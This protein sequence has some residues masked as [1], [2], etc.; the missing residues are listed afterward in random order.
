MNSIYKIVFNK[1]TGTY[2]AVA[3]FA[4]SHTRVGGSSVSGDLS[5]SQNHGKVFTFSTI[6]IAIALSNISY[7]QAQE[8]ALSADAPPNISIGRTLSR[9][10]DV[11]ASEVIVFPGPG[12]IATS[13]P[14]GPGKPIFHSPYSYY[15]PDNK[16]DLGGI[17]YHEKAAGAIAIGSHVDTRSV[18]DGIASGIGLGSYI[19]AKGALSL[20]L[21]SYSSALG[22]S[23]VSL[24]TAAQ[25]KGFNSLAVSRQASAAQDFSMAIGTASHAGARYATAIGQSAQATG[26]GAVALGSAEMEEVLTDDEG[27]YKVTRFN[28]KTNTQAKGKNSVA[29]GRSAQATE[30]NAI[31]QGTRSRAT[32]VNTIAQGTDAK[33]NKI[34]AQAFG[35]RAQASGVNAIAQGASAKAEGVNSIAKG[36]G[37]NATGAGAIAV[38]FVANAK[39]ENAQ[40]FGRGAFADGKNT[41]ALGNSAAALGDDSQAMGV[42]AKS[43]GGRSLALGF[44]AQTDE[45]ANGGLALGNKASVTVADGVALGAHSLGDRKHLESRMV[46]VTAENA[47]AAENKVYSPL[48]QTAI[49]NTKLPG[50]NIEG[51]TQNELELFNE[52]IKNTVKGEYG[53][54]SVGTSTGTRQIINVAAGSEDSDAVNVAQLKALA[55]LPMIF[56]ADD[57]RQ[58]ERK[59]G[60]RLPIKGGFTGEE[61]KA[62]A[63]NIITKIDTDNNTIEVA[64]KPD[65][66]G[67]HSLQF[68]DG[69]GIKIGDA[70]TKAQY[71]ESLA[72]G[73]GAKAEYNLGAIAIGTNAATSYSSQ[74]NVFHANYNNPYS[75]FNLGKDPKSL[76]NRVTDE[77]KRTPTGVNYKN[78]VGSAAIAI[79]RNSE[80][81]HGGVAL[82]DGAQALVA[83]QRGF[84]VAIGA[85]ALSRGGGV[86][87]GS[88]AEAVGINSVAFGRQAVAKGGSAQAYGAASSAVGEKSLALGHS[89]QSIGRR[90]IAIGGSSGN[91][92]EKY[93]DKTNTKAVADDSI[94]IGARTRTG[95]RAYQAIAIG[96]SA[97]ASGVSATAIGTDS[98]ASDH[99]SQALGATA[100]ATKFG[101]QAFGLLASAKERN[102]IA[103]GTGTKALGKNSQ[104]LGTKAE[105]RGERSLAAGFE[106][107]TAKDAANALALGSKANASVA[108]GVALGSESVADRD[109][110]TQPAV[111]THTATFAGGQ[112]YTPISDAVVGD[113]TGST[114]ALTKHR[115][116]VAATT[117][118]TKAAVS[119]GGNGTTRQITNLAAGS[120]DTDAVN[121]A[122]LKSLAAMP[123]IFQADQL[124]QV[125][126]KL[127]ESLPIKG[128]T[129]GGIITKADLATNGLTIEVKPNMAKGIK[130]DENG[131]GVNVNQQGPLTVDDQGLSLT[132]DGEILEITGVEGNKKLSAKA[133]KF[134]ADTG[135]AT[136]KDNAV[137]FDGEKNKLGV[138]GGQTIVG[139]QQVQN[140][141]NIETK[142]DKA[143]NKIEVALK[144]D[145]TNLTSLQFADGKGIKI[146]DGETKATHNDMIAIGKGATVTEG[147][148]GDIGLGLRKAL[149]FNE[150]LSGM[151]TGNHDKYGAYYLTSQGLAVGNQAHSG[152]FATSLGGRAKAAGM[153]A[154]A[155]GTNAY[156]GKEGTVALGAGSFAA[157]ASG[158][159][160]GRE[161]VSTGK[162]AQ[163]LGSVSSATGDK[164]FA[165]GHSATASGKRGIAIGASSNENGTLYQQYDKNGRATTYGAQALG[166]DSI[167]LGSGSVAEQTN[168]LAIGRGAQATVADGVALGSGSKADRGAIQGVST[169]Q[170]ANT[171]N[172][173]YSPTQNEELSTAI[174]DTVKG[175]LGAVSVGDQD[176]TRQITNVAAGSSDTDA[177]NIAQLRALANLPMTFEA[178]EGGQVER[179]LG[180]RLPVKGKENGGITT[181]TNLQTNGIDIA[182]KADDKKGVEVGV[183]GVAV[184]LNTDK[185]VKFGTDG[186]VEVNLAN[187]KGLE[188]DGASD[189]GIAVKAGNGI[190]VNATGVNV[191]PKDQGALTVNADGVAVNVN[192]QKGIEIGTDNKLA[193]KAN[194]TKGIKVDGD[195]IGINLKAGDNPLHFDDQGAL[196][197]NA[198]NVV[199]QAQLPVVYTDKAGNKLTKVGDKFYQVNPLNGNPTRQE[200][201]PNEVIASMNNG[202]NQT[203]NAPMTLANVAHNITPNKDLG[204]EVISYANKPTRLQ[205]N[206]AATVGDVLN[207]GFNLKQRG[208]N[209]D[210]VQAFDT[211]DIIDGAGTTAQ[212]T[213][214]DK[215]QVNQIT[216]NVKADHQTGIKVTD[217]GV[218][219]NIDDNAGLEFKPMTDKSASKL[220]VKADDTTIKV[221]NNTVK[222]KTTTLTPNENGKINTPADGEGDALVTAQ[223]VADAINNSGFTLQANGQDGKL[224]KAGDT[225]SINQ[226]DNINVTQDENGNLTVATKQDVAFETVKVGDT[227]QVDN[228]LKVGDINI[229]PE[230]ITVGNTTDGRQVIRVTSE[231]NAGNEKN[232]ITGLSDTLPRQGDAATQQAISADLDI[233]SDQ[234]DNAKLSR[235]ATVADALSTGFNLQENGNS[236]DFVRAYDTVNF[237]DSD[238]VQTKVA[239]DKDGKISR[240]SNE[241]KVNPNQGLERTQA[242]VGIKLKPSAGNPL[243]VNEYGL[244]LDYDVDKLAVKDQILTVNTTDLFV[245]DDPDNE[246]GNTGRV[247]LD[248]P[249]KAKA[250]VTAQGVADAIN[251]SGFLL[252]AE[253]ETVKLVSPGDSVNI[254]A[255]KTDQGNGNIRVFEDNG[256]IVIGTA[257]DVN[258]NTVKVEEELKVGDVKIDQDGINA[259]N[260]QITNVKEGEKDTDA[261]NVKQLKDSATKYFADTDF[262]ESQTAATSKDKAKAAKDNVIG[263]KGGVTGDEKQDGAS[264]ITTKLISDKNTLEVTLNPV[265]KGLKSI[266][267]AKDQ[268]VTMGDTRTLASNP[269]ATAIG[270]GANATAFGSHAFG[271]DAMANADYA[272]ALGNRAIATAQGAQAMGAFSSADADFAQALGMAAIANKEGALALGAAAEAKTTGG[273]ALGA[274]SV[275]DREAIVG[276]TTSQTAN[277]TNQVYSPTQNEE[278]STAITATVKGNLGAVSV[279]DKNNTRQITN[280]AAGSSDTD[281]AN[282]AQLKAVAE[283][284]FTVED[285][286]GGKAAVKLG[287]NL[288]VKGKANSGITTSVNADKDGIDI[289]VK[290]GNGIEVNATGVN[291][292]PK[293]Q[294]ALTVNAD[295]VAVNVNNQKGIEIGTDN[296]LAVKANTTK[297][298]KVD[299]DGIG[300]NLKAGDNPLHFDDQGALTF[301]AQ[302]VVEQAQLPVVYTD[303]AGNKLTKV[304]DKFYQVNPLNGNPTRQEVAPNE[305][306]ASMNNGL[307]QTQNAPMTLANVA[308]NIT[309][310]KDLG[311][312]VISYANKPTRLQENNAATVG[313]VL[314]AGFNLKQR[315]NNKDFVQA[316]DTLDIIDG[317]GTTAQVTTDDKHQVNQIT[318]NVKAD[319]QT[320]I[321]VTDEGVGINIDDNAGL[322]FKPMTDKSASKLAVKADD[323]TIKVENNTVKAKTTTLTPNE[324]GKINTPAD[325]E[326]D[327]LVTAQTVADA[328]NNSG[329]TLQAN[330]QDGKLVK[331]GDTISIN[332]GDNINVTQDE[333]GNLTVATKQDVA[334]ETVKVGD[335]LQVDNLLKVGDINITPEGITVGNTTDGRQVIRVTSEGNAGNEKNIITGLS[336]TLPRQGDAA[337]QQAISADLD[338]SSDQ[339]D[340]AKLSR[341]ATVADALSTGFNLQENGAAKDFVKAYDTIDFVDGQGTRVMVDSP[342]GD[343]KNTIR[344]DLNLDPAKGLEINQEK[345]GLL[346]IKLR[347]EDSNPL[348]VDENGLTVLTTNLATTADGKL[349]EPD[350]ADENSLVNAKSIVDAINHSGFVAKANGDAGEVIHPGDVLELTNGRN[351][352][353]SRDGGKFT[354]NTA[355]DAIFNSLSV[356]GEYGN[357]MIDEHGMRMGDVHIGPTGIN[358]GDTRITNVADGVDPS[359]AVNVSQLLNGMAQSAEYVTSEDGSIFVQQSVNPSTKATTFDLS[360]NTDDVTITKGDEGKIKAKTTTLTPNEQTGKINT[361]AD[362]E[363]DA[364]VTANTVADAINNSGFTVQAN[365]KDGKLVKAGD[366][367]NFVNG[368]LTTV[369]L[370]PGEN[371]QANTIKVDV[372]AQ[373]LV[374]NAQLPVVYTDKKGNK[375]AKTADGKFVRVNPLTGKPLTNGNNEIDPNEA[376][377]SLNNG[378]NSVQEPMTLN[379]LKHNIQPQPVLDNK[380]TH[381]NK[382]VFDERSLTNAATVG[383]VLNAGFN[384]RQDGTVKDFVQAFDAIDFVKGNATSVEIETNDD[385]TQSKV[386]I[387]I[388]ADNKTIEVKDSQ[389]SAK[390]TTLTPNENGKINTPADGEGDALVTAQTV[391]DAINN[392]GF[393]LQANGQDGKLIKAGDTIS[394]NQGDNIN[395]TQDEN[396]NL[397]VA[398]K[399]DVAFETVK[400]GDTLQV[401]NLLKVGDINITPEGINAGGKKVTNVADGTDDTD[402]VNVK[403]LKDART[404]VTSSDNS[405]SVVDTN[406]GQDGKNLA[407]DI[408]VDSQALVESAQLPVVYTDVYGNRLYKQ[409]DG[410]FAT[411]DGKKVDPADVIASINNGKGSTTQPTNL[412]NVAGNLTPT[413]NAGDMIVGPDGKLIN[414]PVT[415]ATRVQEAPQGQD[416]ANMYNNAATVGDVLNAGFNLQENGWSRDFVKAYDMVNF[417]DGEGT[418]A[419][420]IT[421]QNGKESMIK[422]DINVDDTKGLTIAPNTGKLGI[423][424]N[425]DGPLITD[426]DGLN[427]QTDGSTIKVE[428]NQLIANTATLDDANKD[429]KIEIGHDGDQNALIT[430]G[431]VANAINNSGW[432]VTSGATGTGEVDG[433]TTELINPSETVTFQAGDNLVLNQA[434]NVFTYSLNNDIN[435]SSVQFNDGPKITS[436]GDNIRVESPTGEP[437]K[438]TN[439]QAGTDN[440]DAVNVSQLKDAQAA[441]TTKVEEADGINVEAT[442][443]KDGSTTYTV[444]AKTDGVTTYV[445]NNGNIAA[446]TGDLNTSTDGSVSSEMPNS[447]VTGDQVANAIN[448]SGWN[449][450]ADGIEG[451]ELINPSDTV[452]FKTGSN[453]LTVDR[454]GAD[455]IYDLAD[456]INV[457]SVQFNDGPKITSGGDN[458]RVESPTGEPVKITNVQAGTD[459]NDAV[460]VSQLK[461]AQA[462][463]T[464]KVEEADGINVEA[465]KNKDGSTTYTVSAKTDG[466][467]TYVDNNGNIA[468]I[469]GDLNTSTDGSVSSEM[470]NSLVTGD[471]V[472]NA[473]NNSGWNLAADG[474]EGTELINPSDT[475]TFKTGS[476]NL[477][478]DRQG[479]DIIYDLADDINVSSVQFN[480]GP[481]ITSGGDNIRV[482]SPTGEP[483]KITNVQAGTDNNDAV[484]V[485][486]LKDAQA[487]ATTKV[488]EADGINVEATKNEDGSTT[489]TVSAKTDGVTTYVDNNGNIAAI[490]GDLNT[491]TDGSVSSEMPNSLVTGDQVAN[492]INNSGWNLLNNGAQ[493]DLVR[494]ADAVNFINGK[495]TTALVE[496]AADGKSST[497]KFDINVDGE[498]I[499]VDEDGNLT[500]NK[501]AVDT[502]TVT[503]VTAGKN[504]VVTNTGTA[505]A[506]NYEVATADDVNFNSVTVGPVVINQNGINAGDKKITNV[507]DGDISADSKDAI[508]GS[509]LYAL[510][511]EINTNI[512]AAKTVVDSA[513]KSV[514]VTPSTNPTTGATEYDLSVNTDGDTIKKNTDGALVVNTTP[515]TNNANGAVNTPAA[516]NAIAAAGDVANAINNS[517]FTLTAQGA[518]GSVVNPGETVDMNNTDGN[519]VITKPADS[520]NV[521]YNLAKDVTVDSVTAG[522][523]VV[524]NGGITIAAPTENNPDNVVSLT[525]TGLNNGGNRI[526]NVAP[527]VDMTDAVNVG[528]LMGATNQL[529]GRI[530]NVANQ[531]NAGVSSAMAMA[532]L[533]QAYIPGK[534]ML[535]GGIASY[536]GEGAVAVGFS[537]LSDNGRWVIKASGSADTKG[538]AGG[539]VGAGFHF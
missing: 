14:I 121:V 321:K 4:R 86:V 153:Y 395:V 177:A 415:E 492:A 173:V 301:N 40:A 326:G 216:F 517:G 33:A 496:T 371:G 98:Q 191:K 363:G 47:K 97:E 292:K 25:A 504:M 49:D 91:S 507:A 223:T 163:A 236:R 204:S 203:Q 488:E 324:N 349:V 92:V 338:I 387:N 420:V 234:A 509:Q 339:A 158:V 183:D 73:R 397:T 455:I 241:I 209:K 329:F 353:I 245:S 404:T 296:K 39:G 278:L 161:A 214:D 530:D 51:E 175:N 448:N 325:G 271:R 348:Y 310:N 186:K 484:N 111:A 251:E 19:K 434:E 50:S 230:G 529:A 431:D 450:A 71:P 421:D 15:T 347:D 112:V 106:A 130:I 275:A 53:A 246:D 480:D 332:Q 259:G 457:S 383:D 18:D 127:G 438:I 512:A 479:A 337:T 228:L 284:P 65:V 152:K 343:K 525:Q 198:Q 375:L 369:T 69:Q 68:A 155:V 405:I 137:E 43:R 119:V 215:H 355:K 166:Q 503:T 436:G 462:A 413:Y 74:G 393:T 168:T 75:E 524:N 181:S 232:I 376:I 486:Q 412:A 426:K 538:K 536:N 460:N 5:V 224:V 125:E 315:G 221:E 59:L 126:R 478:V 128:A 302:N 391:A 62:G 437:V 229:T 147:S 497:V 483:V 131:V 21:G 196:T 342:A 273:V 116:D 327:A 340:N 394:I 392:S 240:I 466:V 471:Q 237:V 20:S 24:G 8:A 319:H 299:G 208:N 70:N 149:G 54:V 427:I 419:S 144:T 430:A 165:V 243:N 96:K 441:A 141:K 233:S 389:V 308:H 210:F 378:N 150:Q 528:Q 139:G 424:I 537:K 514:T 279:G 185:G 277:T 160:I 64:L 256:D 170:T 354:I 362:G 225:I 472:A 453:N 493:R 60:E 346:G 3:E 115:T 206:N 78:D 136:T 99:F 120:E 187:N 316:F 272:N 174:T 468:A 13:E 400:V 189:K 305:V 367:V 290:A 490:T 201:A 344:V 83:R 257:D 176:N 107:Q 476:N 30:E 521:T 463:A 433:T 459:N 458:I 151:P 148:V 37:T 422:F 440:N 465:T 322:E 46:E 222:A 298:I 361:P 34:N 370:T 42:R 481:K 341:A 184:K 10:Q 205:E 285:D 122:Q 350:T 117:E 283:L 180:E 104:A 445:D 501:D 16:G 227:L 317:A 523:T 534:S 377:A 286:Q 77:G 366:K 255:E 57:G 213:T 100:E 520:N 218:G 172:Q 408:K 506:P 336:D 82:G 31:A 416:L 238:S 17:D 9:L 260:K 515:L 531:S 388:N 374:E 435:V 482:E 425:A 477:T 446:I 379:N 22:S 399:Q 380:L 489:Y 498:T 386:K 1:A 265:L 456:D 384:L 452:T 373:G 157:G 401:D 467:T 505:D 252:K 88:S 491:S 432:N 41:T 207:A 242:G 508:N 474:I 470:P 253:D 495:G 320:G 334:F 318:F 451:T 295:G 212:V 535:T 473:I 247:Q 142:I 93:D 38:G 414:E 276:A 61:A 29:I 249:A 179:K 263:I 487:A 461:D 138:V 287:D 311:S 403:Q 84:G 108:N 231:G 248:D 143:N 442:K 55:G 288:P 300:I 502:N 72:L 475:V 217:E 443:N 195:G 76:R 36:T 67:L 2:Q 171:T 188:F 345:G 280:V 85:Y 26:E 444:S 52:G 323:T 513:D 44:E 7:A 95:E 423:K 360:A 333:N 133:P 80:G 135:N 313:D 87:I 516:P 351:I 385:Q 101:A 118:N 274:L 264:N 262:D 110:F 449:L 58:V 261:V 447:L 94:A 335:T 522:G 200:V 244:G 309:P 312:E 145:V 105:S 417:I 199:E 511:N 178:D 526:T 407:Y 306:I 267:F 372:N 464:T 368:D 364:L 365:G 164:S 192:N 28:E 45:N 270:R 429:G 32:G 109:R 266:Q 239:T 268:G 123:M 527:G 428:G 197:F 396:G 382:P 297:G 282:I 281:A 533:P 510:A 454:Q 406:Q 63:K 194:T 289:A 235:A 190:E 154:T 485:S 90:S 304:G 162:F 89:A 11:K 352:E 358:A 398:T 500:V 156:G 258:F 226:G 193:V 532:A 494:P 409:P 134:F 79:G 314:N 303:K 307:N 519:I 291:V 132:I 357:V 114:V 410:T 146:G 269:T 294:G 129:N 359:D 439:V 330:G 81:G 220:A 250:L 140:G 66:K 182:V 169:S 211:L 331:A 27:D 418:K 12:N 124:G 381:A 202:L 113:A 103:I 56:E 167:A 328:I 35:N 254:K 219:I 402:A 102:A 356:G 499:T 159:A 469:T 6:A 48:T 539:S 23:S 518:N 390:T 411:K 293:D